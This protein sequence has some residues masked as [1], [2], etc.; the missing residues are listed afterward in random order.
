MPPPA[1]MET[2]VGLFNED[3]IAHPWNPHVFLV[4]RVMTFAWRKALSKDADVMFTA[5]VGDHFWSPAQNEPLIIAIVLPLAHSPDYRGPWLAKGT[6]QAI[7]LE[8]DLRIGFKL[9]AE[10]ATGKLHDVDGRVRKMW[11]DVQGRSRRLLREFLDWARKLPPVQ[12]CVVQ[13]LLYRDAGRPV[14]PPGGDAA[15]RRGKRRRAGGGRGGEVEVPSRPKR[16]PPNGG[17]I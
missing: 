13:G 2:V 15:R 1:V 8:E 7:R 10:D 4:P 12:K 17:S 3:R 5:E 11:K 14:S 9:G 16:R 6:D